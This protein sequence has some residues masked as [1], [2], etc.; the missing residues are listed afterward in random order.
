MFKRFNS[1]QATLLLHEISFI[2]LVLI[3]SSVGIVWSASWQQSSTE[4]L[5][6]GSMNSTVQNIRGELY[7]QLKEVFDASFLHDSDAIEE[8]QSYTRIHSELEKLNFL[9]SDEAE[10]LAIKFVSNAYDAFYEETVVLFRTE[11]LGTEQSQLL[12]DDLEQKTFAQLEI[13]FSRLD[14][15]FRNK[16]QMLTEARERWSKRLIWLVAIPLLIAISLL[17]VARRFVKQNIVLPLSDVINGAKLISKGDLRHDVPVGGVAELVKLS[18]AINTMASDL[19]TSRDIIV[20][21]KK[22]AA[23][24]EL[25]PLVAHNIRNPLAGIRAASQVARDDDVSEPVKETLTD[26]IVAVDRLERWVTSLL[27]YLH[28][29]KP[30]FSETTLIDVADNALSLIELQLVDKSI[31]LKRVGW[32]CVA[33]TLK[34]DNH[35]LEQALFNIV[36]NALEASNDGDVI[37]LSYKQDEESISLT[38]IDEGKGMTF[39]PISEQVLDGETKRLGCGL[40]IPFAL[41]IIKQHAGKLT[42]RNRSN[43][44]TCVEIRLELRSN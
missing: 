22:Q 18:E 28:P 14:L 12:D 8:Y 27:S 17:L 11:K 41:K 6:I 37:T 26:I 1:L 39:D 35:L 24:G 25:V 15:L 16:Q 4:S 38:V 19:V 36:Q 44:G 2:L 42:Y 43:G 40:G 3:T 34:L 30:H 31:K 7:R 10:L 13:G 20:E 23:M 5:R 21:T 29:M 33:K 9:A 32:E